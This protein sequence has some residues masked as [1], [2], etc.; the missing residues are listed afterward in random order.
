[1]TAWIKDRVWTYP[2]LIIPATLVVIAQ[3]ASLIAY[4]A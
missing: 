2:T 1:M 4:L 3:I